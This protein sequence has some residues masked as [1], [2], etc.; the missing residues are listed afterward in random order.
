MLLTSP[1]STM[2]TPTLETILIISSEYFN[3]P[4]DCFNYD[5]IYDAEEYEEDKCNKMLQNRTN[6]TIYVYGKYYDSVYMDIL[7]EEFKE[8]YIK[9]K[10]I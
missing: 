10:N 1:T 2:G 9:N 8:E 7:K 5:N 6:G 4:D 3:K